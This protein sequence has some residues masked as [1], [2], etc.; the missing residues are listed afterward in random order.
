MSDW[1]WRLLSWLKRKALPQGRSSLIG[2]L[3]AQRQI[4]AGEALL[5]DVR[6]HMELVRG[7]AQPARWLP[8]SEFSRRSEVWLR[9]VDS[10]PRDMRIIVYCAG[11]VRAGR[12]ADALADLGFVTANLGGFRAWKNAGLPIRARE[13]GMRELAQP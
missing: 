1:L 7:L 4:E 6:E 3:E 2:A 10:L 13:P 8:T 11:G 9:F 12:V 5:V